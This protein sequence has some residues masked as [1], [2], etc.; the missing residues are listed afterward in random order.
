MATQSVASRTAGADNPE[1]MLAVRAAE[2]GDWATRNAKL[3]IGLGVAGLIV[4]FGLLYFFLIW[5]PAQAERVAAEFLQVQQTAY[6][7]TP[8]VAVAELNTFIARNAGSVQADEARMLLAERQ[9]EQGQPQ[10]AVTTLQP[11]ADRVGSSPLGPQAALLLAAA[12]VAANQQDAAL[13]TY[14][15]VA[16]E[17]ELAYLK[18]EA[19]TGAAALHEQKGD[20][21]AAADLYRRLVESAEEG[22]VQ[23][24]VWEMRLAEAEAASSAK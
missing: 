17:A 15:R 4:V 8:Q 20:M 22:S 19:L 24:S 11:L 23:R 7:A 14:L 16:D 2:F 21:A 5:K 3:V 1:D 10:Q 9:I 12:Q 6:S 13:A 18:E